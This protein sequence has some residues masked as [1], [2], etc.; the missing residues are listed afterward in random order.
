[1]KNIDLAICIDN[2]DPENIGRIRYIR[3]NSYTGEIERA[4]NYEKWGDKDLFIA[5][6]F[7]PTNLNFIPDIGQSVK[8]INYDNEKDYTNSEY[9]AGP[10]TTRHDFNAQT[11]SNQV[12]KTTY[13]ISNKH[14]KKVIDTNGKYVNPKSEGVFAKHSDFGI[15]GKYGS[16][17]LF[18]ENGLQLRGGKLIS[19][20][21]A[22]PKQKMEMLY[23]P[24]MS[25][26]SSVLYLKKFHETKEFR[27][28]EE[29][30]QIPKYR[31]LNY[32]VEYA[33]NKFTGT[34]YTID[35]YVYKITKPFED[36]YLTNNPTLS[37]VK[38]VN[39][40]YKLIN[41]D[42]SLTTPTYSKEVTSIN[43]GYVTIRNDLKK[44]HYR[45]LTEFNLFYPKE[46]IHPFYFRPTFEC[47]NRT[48]NSTENTNRTT[49]FRN[50]SISSDCGPQF[51]LAYQQSTISPPTETVNKKENVLKI[52]NTGEEQSFSALKSDKI[53]FLSSDNRNVTSKPINF[54]KL[55]KYD[56]TQE[57]YLL[58]I[59][60]NT[61]AMVR[62]ETLLDFLRRMYEVLTTHIHNINEP[63]A[64]LSYDAHIQLE[65]SF[66]I[67]EN[68]M[69][70]KHIRIN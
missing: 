33:I 64:K 58:D 60:P 54:E 27:E 8:I 29:I 25:K 39:N 7:L 53:Y 63:Y 42:N 11:Y 37:E 51:G 35:Y 47:R 38:L 41:P 56:L 28:N 61:Y 6:P 48:V 34:T 22:T 23:Q 67:L 70:N 46:D 55:D 40:S 19:K 45:G 2:E 32:M 12:E 52:T 49:L 36:H 44:L 50:I 24:L 26:K 16:D 10:F 69:L 1:M 17:I 21:F 59:E 9:I 14:G 57:N 13:G 18:T 68:D 30:L 65:S 5:I 15:Y 43:E 20:R 66:Q 62:G 31:T 4:L 3:E